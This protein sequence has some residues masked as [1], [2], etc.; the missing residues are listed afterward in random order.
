[1]G[2]PRR[3]L[4]DAATWRNSPTGA[5]TTNNTPDFIRKLDGI[6]D[7]DHKERADLRDLLS[8]QF[9]RGRESETMNS[10]IP[11]LRWPIR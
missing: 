9:A 4:H 3:P 11:N 7:L 1:M 5:L 8:K 10:H 2:D 6:T